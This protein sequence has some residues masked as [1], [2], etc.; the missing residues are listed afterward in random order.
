M[1]LN[2][3]VVSKRRF[4]KG[5]SPAGNPPVA[6]RKTDTTRTV[7]SPM[8]RHGKGRYGGL[9]PGSGFPDDTLHLLCRQGL[10]DEINHLVFADQVLV[11]EQ[12]GT[13]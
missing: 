9:L 7:G 6:A 12:A 8:Y 11:F 10:L 4:P 1:T 2:E 5:Y 13:A 3:T